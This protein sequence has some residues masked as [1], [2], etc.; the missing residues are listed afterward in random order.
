V[1]CR[2]PTV[3]VD[4]TSCGFRTAKHPDKP[5]M[6]QCSILPVFAMRGRGV[7]EYVSNPVR[8]FCRLV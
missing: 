2:R 1:E 4:I 3:G 5:L 6:R 8:G 7:T